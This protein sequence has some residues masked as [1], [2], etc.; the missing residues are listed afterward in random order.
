MKKVIKANTKMEERAIS[1]RIFSMIFSFTAISTPLESPLLG[2]YTVRC[3]A[4]SA[5]GYRIPFEAS[6]GLKALRFAIPYE[7]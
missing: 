3:S 7:G 5:D 4:C 2:P 1:R 6:T